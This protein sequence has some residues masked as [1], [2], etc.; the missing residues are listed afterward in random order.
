MKILV[1]LVVTL[2]SFTVANAHIESG[3]P[4]KG[5]SKDSLYVLKTD[6][7][8]V[9]AT[10]EIYSS[11]GTLVTSQNLNKRKMIIDFGPVIRDTYTIR[12]VKGKETQE[13]HFER[14]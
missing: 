14:K 5:N 8:F 9:G 11:E 12:V 13:F 7:K 6:K 10:V 4:S 3:N 2:F 1:T